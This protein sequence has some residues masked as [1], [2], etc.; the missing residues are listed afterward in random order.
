MAP[1]LVLGGNAPRQD[2]RETVGAGRINRQA[3]I[4]P[5]SAS[6]QPQDMIGKNIHR[7]H[8]HTHADGSHY[9][10]EECP[11]YK[12][13]RDGTLMTFRRRAAGGAGRSRGYA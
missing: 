11:I 4:G 2:R 7:I 6:H 5:K 12:A 8:H 10:V 3:A 13:V 1:P 9:P